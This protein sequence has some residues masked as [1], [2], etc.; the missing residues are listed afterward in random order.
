MNPIIDP[1][2]FYWISTLDSLKTV[3]EIFLTFSII[4]ALILAVVYFRNLYEENWEELNKDG[5]YVVVVPRWV[6]T[7]FVTAII[8]FI[9][10]LLM[11][12]FIPDKNTMYQMLAAKL[13]TPANIES[14]I[15]SGKD[16]VKFI[17]DT[18]VNTINSVK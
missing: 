8:I 2:I 4:G 17:S 18:I 9:V 13:V 16:L 5:D 7:L 12:I 15:G 10:S 1:N 3:A 11:T 6:R 14:A